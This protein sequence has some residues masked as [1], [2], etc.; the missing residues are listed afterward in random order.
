MSK[1]ED[2]VADALNIPKS[3]PVIPFDLYD[4]DNVPFTAKADLLFI[5]DEGQIVF[6]E[7]KEHPLNSKGSIEKSTNGLKA[8]CGHRRLS[9]GGDHNQL[10]RRLYF[11]GHNIDCLNHAW[12]HSYVKHSIIDKVL[13]DNDYRYLL[14]FSEHP[15]TV[16]ENG[17]PWRI[18]Y[19]LKG[20]SKVML[21]DE[22]LVQASAWRPLTKLPELSGECFL[23]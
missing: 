19:Q 14:V 11:A 5:D 4:K 9:D 3:D 7:L 18:H 21:Q 10:S 15:P 2:R 6:V 1:I 13:R 20:I 17:V 16:G 23:A 22:F 8:Q 12:N